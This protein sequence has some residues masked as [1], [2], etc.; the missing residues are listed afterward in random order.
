MGLVYLDERAAIDMSGAVNVPNLATLSPLSN[1]LFILHNAEWLARVAI[2]S[3]TS[4]HRAHERADLQTCRLS[5]D[6]VSNSTWQPWQYLFSGLSSSAMLYLLP[7]PAPAP[8]TANLGEEEQLLSS[9]GEQWSWTCFF[10]APAFLNLFPHPSQVRLSA[11]SLVKDVM[12]LSMLFL[13]L[14]HRR[15]E[16][17]FAGQLKTFSHSGHR[18]STWTIMEHLKNRKKDP[19]WNN[20]DCPFVREKKFCS[21]KYHQQEILEVT[22]CQSPQKRQDSKWQRKEI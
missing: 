21:P 12:D 2:L 19:S 3:N 4:G 22:E 11:D 17:R 15:W 1:W 13:G 5:S 18:Y 10:S 7:A 16:A 9:V 6:K 20:R 14:C 8:D